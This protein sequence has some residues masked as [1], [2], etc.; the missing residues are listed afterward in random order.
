MNRFRQ[1][2][3]WL[4]ALAV[5]GIAFSVA[6]QSNTN[7]ALHARMLHAP[8][9][10][11]PPPSPVDYF[12]HLLAMSPEQRESILAN[13][14]PG[15]REKILAKVNEY[16]ALDLDNRELRLRAT[17]LHWYLMPLLRAAPDDR[18]ARLALVPDDL[19]GLVSSRLTQWEILPPQLQQEFLDNERA[20]SYFS[21][22]DVTNHV[23]GEAAPSD[24]DQSR[25]NALSGDERKTMTAQFNEFFS[26][27][28]AEKQK[29][30][31]GL[32]GAERAQMEKTIQTFGQ[33]PPMQRVQCIRA[34]GKFAN[35]SPQERVDFLQN[36]QRW[37]KMTAADRKA[38]IDL[39]AHVP[40]W[41][42]APPAMI[43]PPMPP[44][45]SLHSLEV[46]NRS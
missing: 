38:W 12:R 24:A 15:V 37:S 2:R 1:G 8:A 35:M 5:A 34:F 39:V 42:P 26:L 18:A 14:P 9:S 29:A 13:K 4:A 45:P 25:W 23:V 22:M 10:I 21:S 31:G 46:T 17:E 7:L 27:T 33:L 11:M 44:H 3:Q 16:A 43:M 40:Q 28:P 36:A 30:L 6:A 20:L 19:R 41:S 32:S